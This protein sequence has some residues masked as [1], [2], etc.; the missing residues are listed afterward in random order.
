MPP[1]VD[2]YERFGWDYEIINPLTEREVSW[3]L[4][5]TRQTGGPLLELACGT[6]RLLERLALN[7]IEVTGIDLSRFMLQSASGRFKQLPPVVQE[8]I[9]LLRSDM[10]DFKFNLKFGNIIIADNSFREL[11]DLN[12]QRSCLRCIQRHLRSDGIFLMT[13][14]HCNP[15][16][17][18][19]N[20]SADWSKPVRNERTGA[21]IRRK[22]EMSVQE[23]N[24]MII[25]TMTYE[26][27]KGSKVETAKYSFK[28]PVM[29][30]DDYQSLLSDNGFTAELYTNYKTKCEIN[31]DSILCFVC[32]KANIDL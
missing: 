15:A 29:T 3:Y 19:C 11:I 9:Q 14:R 26:S 30:I 24:R 25:T 23:E 10:T 27:R 6:G 1:D 2:R 7:G 8:R 21:V 13:V 28:A 22:V 20:G 4:N 5:F 12:Q 17:L 32:R 16:R 18:S 31:K